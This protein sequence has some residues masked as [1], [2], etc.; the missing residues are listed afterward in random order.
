VAVVPLK[1]RIAELERELGRTRFP[2]PEAFQ[3]VARGRPGD[4]AHPGST[5]HLQPAP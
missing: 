1:A 2:T 4:E 5:S 3:P